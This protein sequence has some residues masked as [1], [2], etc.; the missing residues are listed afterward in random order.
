MD[1]YEKCHYVVIST[2]EGLYCTNK[3]DVNRLNNNCIVLFFFAM[4]LYH[5][6]KELNSSEGMSINERYPSSYL[7]WY[8]YDEYLLVSIR[9]Y[10]FDERPS[11]TN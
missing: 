10:V 7:Q 11:G 8:N 9:Q 3:L 6:Q 5:N 4:L 1:N 2:K